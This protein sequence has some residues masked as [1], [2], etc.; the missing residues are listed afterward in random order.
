VCLRWALFTGTPSVL[1]CASAK[2][3]IV[4]ICQLVDITLTSSSTTHG[5]SRC[6][7][8]EL[9]EKVLAKEQRQKGNSHPNGPPN[10]ELSMHLLMS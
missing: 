7:V 2:Q 9:L 10:M 1:A 3:M 6:E 8:Q 4:L 5:T